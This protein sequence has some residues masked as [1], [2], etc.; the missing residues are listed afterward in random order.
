MNEPDS[1][2]GNIEVCQVVDPT[3]TSTFIAPNPLRTGGVNSRMSA[4]NFFGIVTKCQLEGPD[5]IHT[6]D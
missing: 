3:V 5:H 2:S 6:R 1:R 4:A